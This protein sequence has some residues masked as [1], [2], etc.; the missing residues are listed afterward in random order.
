MLVNCLFSSDCCI[1]LPLAVNST[2]S[3]KNILNT[4]TTIQ[5]KQHTSNSILHTAY[6]ILHN[7]Y[8]IDTTAHTVHTYCMYMYR[9]KM[10]VHQSKPLQQYCSYSIILVRADFEIPKGCT[11]YV[12]KVDF[13]R[14]SFY[15]K[16]NSCW[17]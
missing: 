1:P 7:A 13:Q 12:Q 4:G 9:K 6:C 3:T 5:T 16:N 2:G 14:I 11:S 17:A 10:V 8:C 15:L